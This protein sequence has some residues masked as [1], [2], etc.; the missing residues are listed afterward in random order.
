M[1]SLISALISYR[2]HHPWTM[3]RSKTKQGILVQSELFPIFSTCRYSEILIER[4][5]KTAGTIR[6]G[7]FPSI[8]CLLGCGCRGLQFLRL[9]VPSFRLRND[10]VDVAVAENNVVHNVVPVVIAPGRHGNARLNLRILLRD[11]DRFDVLALPDR[12]LDRSTRSTPDRSRTRS[13]LGRSSTSALP[14]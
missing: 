5:K 7:Q 3:R 9:L 11:F 13:R 14:S 6:P 8:F 2:R 1:L 12:R 4:S 10:V